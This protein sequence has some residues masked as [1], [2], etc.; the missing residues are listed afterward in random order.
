M[1]ILLFLFLNL[2]SAMCGLIDLLK[3]KLNWQAQNLGRN[4]YDYIVTF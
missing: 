3:L 4:I 1:D 2:Q